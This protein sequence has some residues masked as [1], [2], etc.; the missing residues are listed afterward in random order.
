M[1]SI[2]NVMKLLC[3][4]FR[5]RMCQLTN[6]MTHQ[7]PNHNLFKDVQSLNLTLARPKV[8]NT[9]PVAS[10]SGSS[11][12]CQLTFAQQEA[13]MS[14]R[15]NLTISSFCWCSTWL[16]CLETCRN[17][18]SS[19]EE[20]KCISLIHPRSIVD[21][22]LVQIQIAWIR[23]V[24]V[25]STCWQL[26]TSISERPVHRSSSPQAWV[27]CRFRARVKCVLPKGSHATKGT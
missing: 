15:F 1:R 10:K 22:I 27:T 21:T 24:L 14:K 4:S 2:D 7:Y 26:L 5:V 6:D 19:A 3:S 23:A 17:S 18:V 20:L 25:Q 16:E 8:L 12:Q 9:R 11:S 13:H